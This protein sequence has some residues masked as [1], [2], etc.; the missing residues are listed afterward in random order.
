MPPPSTTGHTAHRKNAPRTSQNQNRPHGLTDL[1]GLVSAEEVLADPHLA[2]M[3]DQRGD[4]VTQY[5][6][7]A[8]RVENLLVRRPRADA[9]VLEAEL[10]SR[11]CAGGRRAFR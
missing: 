4:S 9:V 5:C 7:L 8:Q 10:V 1:T 11:G 3:V 6:I 2:E